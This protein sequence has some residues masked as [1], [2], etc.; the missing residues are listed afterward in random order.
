M[1]MA[2]LDMALTK[3]VQTRLFGANEDDLQQKWTQTR[4]RKGVYFLLY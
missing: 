2:R 3:G 4:L 1:I